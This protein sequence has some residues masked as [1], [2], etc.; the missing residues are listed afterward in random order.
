MN[1]S[2]T[3]QHLV[4]LLLVLLMV[5]FWGG[6]AYALLSG[7]GTA[8]SPYIITN[9]EDWNAFCS[10]VNHGVSTYVPNAWAVLANDIT[11][12]ISSTDQSV[13]GY[14]VGIRNESTISE[15]Y[16][17][18]GTFD[19]QGHTLTFNFETNTNENEDKGKGLFPAPFRYVSNGAVIKNL[20]VEGTIKTSQKYA[21]GIVGRAEGTVTITNCISNITIDSSVS[22]DGTHGG[23]VGYSSNSFDNYL[24]IGDCLFNGKLLGSNTNNCGGFEGGGNKCYIYSSFFTPSQVTISTSGSAT[25]TRAPYPGFDDCYYLQSFGTAQGTDANGLSGAELAQNLGASW[26]THNDSV[27]VTPFARYVDISGWVSGSAPSTPTITGNRS[28]GSVAYKYKVKDSGD[29]TYSTSPPTLPGHYTVKAS[30]PAGNDANGQYWNAWESTMEFCVVG[31]PNAATDL[32]YNGTAQTLLADNGTAAVGTFYY[33]LGTS[34]G[35]STTPPSATTGGTYTIYYYVKSPDVRHND[36]GSQ[37]EPAGSVN[38]TI[39]P[40]D[41]PSP[42]MTLSETSMTYTG[43]ELKPSVTV[44]DGD[45]L[46]DPS[47][48]T[49][50]YMNN[51]NVGT[52]SVTVYENG[53]GGN[54]TIPTVTVLNFEIT[55]APVS[56]TA[57]KARTLTYKAEPQELV[58]AGTITG[59][60]STK[61]CTMKYCLDGQNYS[62]A[63]P[64]GTQAKTYTVYYR[65]DG[66]MN[67]EGLVPASLT[68]TINP[69]QLGSAAIG[70]SPSSFV[71]DG[72]AKEPVVSVLDGETPI[73]SSEYTVT[74]SDNIQ[75][76]TAT[77]TVKDNEGGN[78]VINGSVQFPIVAADAGYVPPTPK[79][80][81]IYNTAAQELVDAGSATGGTMQYSLDGKT[82]STTIP[83]GTD[84]KE[85]TIYYKV[86]GDAN[87]SDREAKTVKVTLAAK[88]VDSPVIVITPSAIDYDGNPKTPV[89]TVRDGDTVIPASEYTITYS[90]NVNVGTATVK[91][92]DKPDGN[93]TVNGTAIF[94]VVDPI[95][96]IKQPQPMTGL[97]YNGKM[98]ELIVAGVAPDGTMVYSLD[99][100]TYS[101]AIPTA[102][103]AGKYTVWYKVV[104]KD[105]VDKTTPAKVTATINPKSVNI[106][107]ILTGGGPQQVPGITVVDEFDSVMDTDAYEIVYK[108]ANGK[109]VKPSNG[110]LPEGEYEVI[111]R[112]TGNYTG[113]AVATSFRVRGELSF[114]FTM[115]SD[116]IAVTLPYSRKLPDSY[117]AY[118]FD[119]LDDHGYPVFK[120]IQSTQLFAGEPYLLRYT[121]GSAATRGSRQLDLSPSNPALVDLSTPIHEQMNGS[122]IFTGIFDD[123]SNQKAIAEGAY[124]LQADN[125]WK[126]SASTKQADASKICLDAFHAYLHYRNHATS[127][128]ILPVTVPG[129]TA[130]NGIILED[131]DGV[132][133][134]YDLNGRRIDGPQ[135]GVNILRT[136]SGQTRKVVIR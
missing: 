20:R 53:A 52:A 19:G 7:S 85:Y 102:K 104:G 134:W 75:V 97:V 5:T 88:L 81:L 48:Y 118:R 17:Y 43:S 45:D 124:I 123:M 60:G 68:V 1:R 24:K 54:Y 55:K 113:P 109:E 122:I 116:L 9:A 57:P 128:E 121:G 6:H 16:P 2:S 37:S 89:V 112:P 69:K 103:D 21:G 28:A 95:S 66:D 40:K 125:T 12:T 61:D 94:Y 15:Y 107:V 83:T 132:Q 98:R 111:V 71:Y 72:T 22:G 50:N 11:V 4:R 82:Y 93:Y 64:T 105:N 46:I 129:A 67:H 114:V 31:A 39:Q 110:R 65:V 130:I 136:K 44:K 30:I 18:S 106:S 78:Y 29:N 120:E 99:G 131:E 90:D 135:R 49:V 13:H 115:E 63:I 58:T 92:E 77:V 119:R 32:H 26:T 133:A 84:A 86:V 8:E 3:Y 33:R 70:I 36:I 59:A 34:G 10:R 41:L 35:W 56:A 91:I 47:E 74:Y 23:L 126:A 80:G 76:G 87:H 14:M 96:V 100:K 62:V 27:Y 38:V 51:T 117:Q 127:D 73:P 79:Q 25:F 101:I 42:A 108:D